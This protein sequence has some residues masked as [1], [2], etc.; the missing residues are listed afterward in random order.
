MNKDEKVGI[1]QCSCHESFG[2]VIH[3]VP[4]CKICPHCRKRIA[5]GMQPEHLKHCVD[6]KQKSN[7]QEKV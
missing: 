5:Q 4:C 3:V 2:E 6:Y 7:E 1:C